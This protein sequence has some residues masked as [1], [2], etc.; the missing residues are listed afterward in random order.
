LRFA[1]VANGGQ[2]WG[3]RL[4]SPPARCWWLAVRPS[5]ARGARFPRPCT[6]AVDARTRIGAGP[7]RNAKGLVIAANVAQLHDDA[8]TNL[9]SLANSL[10]ESGNE[11]PNNVHDIPTGSNIEGT[12][13]AN[14]HCNNWTVNTGNTVRMGHTNR[15]GGGSTSWKCSPA[16]KRRR[17]RWCRCSPR[18]AASPRTSRCC[19]KA[20]KSR[21][22]ASC[23]WVPPTTRWPRTSPRW[24][25]ASKGFVD[26][27]AGVLLHPLGDKKFCATQL[28]FLGPDCDSATFAF[29]R[30]MRGDRD[31][32]SVESVCAGTGNEQSHGV[33]LWDYRKGKLESVF[34]YSVQETVGSSNSSS[35]L[36]LALEGSTYPQVIAVEVTSDWSLMR[37]TREGR[38]AS[39]GSVQTPTACMQRATW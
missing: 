30:A 16:W 21:A 17:A 8:G 31:S 32:F 35:S 7:W 4:C 3:D 33:S 23:R 28:P 9:L 15:M 39:S 29:L 37:A 5:K 36:K 24:R 13:F 27:R 18:C 20:P 19:T 26:Y 6:A 1:A 25:R 12:V 34:E 22:P 38:H 14:A 2:P 11:V 10:T